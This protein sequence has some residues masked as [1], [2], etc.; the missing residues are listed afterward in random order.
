MGV[1][2]GTSSATHGPVIRVRL[3]L[4][5]AEARRRT[6]ANLP[7]AAS[8]EVEALIDT[9]AE[10]TCISSDAVRRLGAAPTMLGMVNTAAMSG[11]A[12]SLEYVLDLRIPN[13]R[14]S[15]ASELVVTDLTVYE[16][17]LQGSNYE[18]LLGRDVL[19]HC[20]LAFDGLTDSFT[21]SH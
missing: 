20:V 6:R 12:G 11:L 16:I 9:G 13:P 3:S 10:V 8:I 7:P 5:R 2:H 21:L 19:A 15:M 1:H 14:G 4:T 17:D 18:L